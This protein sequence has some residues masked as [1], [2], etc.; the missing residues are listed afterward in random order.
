VPTR[1]RIKFNGAD[2]SNLPSLFPRYN[3]APSQ[4]VLAVVQHDGERE[5][6][7]L[8]WGLIP[9]WSKRRASVIG[10]KDG[11]VLFRQMV[12]MSLCRQLP[13]NYKFVSEANEFISFMEYRRDRKTQNRATSPA[14]PVLTDDGARGALQR[15][16]ILRA[17]SEDCIT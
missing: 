10:F 2:R 5:A 8:Q 13:V 7:F 3:I 9:S 16:P 4:N 1:T 12:F 6:A 11:D 14:L 15:C 17:G